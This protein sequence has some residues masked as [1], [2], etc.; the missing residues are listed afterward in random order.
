[1]I[2]L[3]LRARG[4]NR[5]WVPNDS[6][7]GWFWFKSPSLDLFLPKLIPVTWYVTVLLS[8]TLQL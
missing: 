1:M 4:Y 2:G 3:M 7:L 8:H 6:L 5:Q